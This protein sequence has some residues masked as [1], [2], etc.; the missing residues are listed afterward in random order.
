MHANA[1]R[2]S[3]SSAVNE[4]TAVVLNRDRPD[5][6][7]RCVRSLLGDG[8][9]AER[10]VVVDNGSEDDSYA[11]FQAELHGCGLLRLE[12]NV[13]FARAANSGARALPAKAYLFVD[14]DAFVHRPGSVDA[15]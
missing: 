13:G 5:L 7:I 12:Q 2:R 10:V 8:V 15:L 11:Q 6:T 3:F 14:N 1:D 9:P 4:L